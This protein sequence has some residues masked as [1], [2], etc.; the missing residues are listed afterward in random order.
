MYL[1]TVSGAFIEV[2]KH[3]IENAPRHQLVEYLEMRG[4]AC[5]DSEPTELLREAAL[6]D[7]EDEQADV[8]FTASPYDLSHCRR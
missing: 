8:N 2:S 3:Y 5:F 6:E 7:F 4:S 1:E